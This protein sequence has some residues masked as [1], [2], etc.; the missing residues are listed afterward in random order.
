MTWLWVALGA[1]VGAPLRFV[2]SSWLDGRFLGA[3]PWGTLAVNTAGSALL[4]W[5]SALALGG[6]SAALLGV[7][8]C[9]GLTT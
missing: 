8:F 3:L 7:G 9:G 4:G 2:V 5:F 6:P 1:A